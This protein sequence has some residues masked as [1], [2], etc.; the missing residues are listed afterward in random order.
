M[1]VATTERDAVVQAIAS[2]STRWVTLTVTEKG[3]TPPLGQLLT[4]GLRLRH[5]AGLS[6]I[7]IASCDNLQGNGHKLQALVHAQIATHEHSVHDA[8]FLCWLDAHSRGDG[9]RPRGAGPS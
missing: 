2:P 9:R 4:E 5:Q 6:G 3:Y 7:T 1:S 8:D